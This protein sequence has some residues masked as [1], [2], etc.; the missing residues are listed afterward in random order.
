MAVSNLFIDRI[1]RKLKSHDI[2]VAVECVVEICINTIPHHVR[3]VHDWVKC[4]LDDINSTDIKY[5]FVFNFIECP[6]NINDEIRYELLLPFFYSQPKH[7]IFQS[8]GFIRYLQC[9]FIDNDKDYE[10]ML[11]N[12]IKGSSTFNDIIQVTPRTTTVHPDIYDAFVTNCSP[13][14]KRMVEMKLYRSLSETCLRNGKVHD[15]IML[16]N[17]EHMSAYFRHGTSVIS[18][19]QSVYAQ[20]LM[21]IACHPKDAICLNGAWL[22]ANAMTHAEMLGLIF[23]M[24]LLHPSTDSC[25]NL[26]KFNIEYSYTSTPNNLLESELASIVTID[27]SK[28]VLFDMI[29]LQQ[30]LK[31]YFA[32]DVPCRYSANSFECFLGT[33]F[34]R[35][36]YYGKLQDNAGGYCITMPEFYVPISSPDQS[37]FSCW[38]NA[39]IAPF[40]AF[41]YACYGFSRKLF[42]SPVLYNTW[43]VY[44]DEVNHKY[45]FH[46]RAVGTSVTSMLEKVSPCAPFDAAAISMRISRGDE[47]AASQLR[48]D[49]SNRAKEGTEMHLLLE[50]LCKGM[51]IQD[52]GKFK[53][54]I[55]MFYEFVI[56]EMNRMGWSLE[57]SI[58]EPRVWLTVNDNGKKTILCGSVDLVL[59]RERN[60]EVEY[61]IWDWK[62]INFLD[63][64]Y[65]STAINTPLTKKHFSVDDTSWIDQPDVGVNRTNL[66]KYSRQLWIYRKFFIDNNLKFVDD[67]MRIVK[68]N[69]NCRG[70]IFPDNTPTTCMY[71]RYTEPNMMVR[72]LDRRKVTDIL[73]EFYGIRYKC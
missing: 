4:L 58:T 45:S 11:L 10:S 70:F 23:W 5:R 3:S 41:D 54:E 44:F 61:T 33:I 32:K 9:M 62:R 46:N 38:L 31:V 48:K 72:P 14:L 73:C 57:G 19:T 34:Q 55:D 69:S 7:P 28:V 6:D 37:E 2:N 40:F 63:F 30:I 50:K 12:C 53:P 36:I 39:S 43:M 47:L 16:Q 18:T 60:G 29:K 65:G 20:S 35:V 56:P 1:H 13:E 49:W 64:T 66:C 51:D 8:V 25:I 15:T 71:T 42:E 26:S 52:Y 68:L 24:F 17:S 27:A 67:D 59:K 21:Y 22:N